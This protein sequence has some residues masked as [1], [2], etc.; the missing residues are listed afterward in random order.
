MGKINQK[1]KN[2]LFAYLPLLGILKIGN[3]AS[4][5]RLWALTSHGSHERPCLLY[6]LCLNSDRSSCQT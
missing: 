3:A 2:P 6:V 5:T 4:A 1:D